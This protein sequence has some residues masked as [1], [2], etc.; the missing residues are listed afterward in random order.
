M[1]NTQ[2]NTAKKDVI[3]VMAA[4]F[5][6]MFSVMFVTPLINGYALSLGASASFA[7]V[8][9]GIMSFASLFVRPLAGNI[10]D[11]VSKYRL[12]FLGGILIFVG[13]AGYCISPNSEWLLL[14][15]LINGLGFVLCTVCMTTW[16]GVL[17]P[18]QHVGRAMGFYGLMNAL[19][20]AIAP[21]ISIDVYRIIGFRASFVLAGIASV[22]MILVIQFVGNKA[23]PDANTTKKAHHFQII[24]P[25]AFPVTL[26]TALVSMPYFITQADI[27]TYVSQRHLAVHEGLYFIVYA[28][29]LLGLRIILRD[30]F[31]TTPF[32]TW[33]YAALVSMVGYLIVLT[34]MQND[35]VMVLAAVLMAVGYGIIY[36]VLQATA[37]LLAPRSQQGLASSTFYMGIDLGMSIGPMLGGLISTYLPASDFYLVQLILVP[38]A[39]VVYAIYRKRLNSAILHH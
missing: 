14:F 6:F 10:C 37:M 26:I 38:L 15:R 27:V 19:D 4:S 13:I 29:V 32:K 12:S 36:S 22:L 25:N 31:D 3:L 35:W 23:K 11:M 8:I 2:E 7:G 34:E 18:R 16:L 21:A 17:V 20:M 9:V 5:F 24:Q 39:W 1:E 33:F 28:L 30:Y